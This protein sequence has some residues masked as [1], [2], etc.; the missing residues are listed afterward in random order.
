M[1]NSNRTRSD[2]FPTKI[3]PGLISERDRKYFLLSEEYKKSSFM[4]I[5]MFIIKP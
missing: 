3:A 2:F 1:I 5:T 4:F